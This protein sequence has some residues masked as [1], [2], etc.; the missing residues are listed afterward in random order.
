MNVELDN[1]GRILI[2]VDMK[3]NKKISKDVVLVSTISIIEI[4]D[5]QTY[6]ELVNNTQIDIAAL[7]EER[8]G[9]IT[10]EDIS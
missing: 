1:N 9:Q 10:Q 7:A 5:K 4:W 2:P 3:K 6:D 8:L